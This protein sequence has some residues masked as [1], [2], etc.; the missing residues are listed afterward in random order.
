MDKVPSQGPRI[1]RQA[2]SPCGPKRR[3]AL[4]PAATAFREIK[5]AL[6]ALRSI[7]DGLGA[8]PAWALEADSDGRQPPIRQRSV[9]LQIPGP[10]HGRPNGLGAQD[11]RYFVPVERP[12]ARAVVH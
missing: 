7:A 5:A 10:H 6:R 4:S 2:T 11:S 3:E 9:P 1:S 8:P 12:V